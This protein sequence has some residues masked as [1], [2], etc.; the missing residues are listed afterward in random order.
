MEKVLI[1]WGNLERTEAI[2]ADIF[3]KVSKILTFA[4]SATSTIVHLTTVNP[5]QS[6]GV[7]RQKVSIQVRLPNHQDVQSEK[8]DE[9][10]YKSLKE[11][12]KAIL[13]QIKAKKDQ[14]LI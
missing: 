8:E 13:K 1:E 3:D 10:V 11:A 6:A 7:N 12:Q 5:T 14:H 9:D 2:E 4:P